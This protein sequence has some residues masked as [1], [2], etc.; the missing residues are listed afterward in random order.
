MPAHPE[1]PHA[2]AV[3]ITGLTPSIDGGRHPVK[4]ITD[5]PLVVEADVFKDGHDEIAAAVL[6]KPEGEG[7]WREVPMV[8][9]EN[10]RWTA[11]LR[12]A[13]PGRYEFRVAAWPDPLATWRHELRKKVEA[14]VVPLDLELQEG[15]LLVKGAAL[16][17]RLQGETEIARDLVQLGE[18][19]PGLP[20]REAL[21]LVESPEVAAVLAHW[22]DRALLTLH[23]VTHAVIVE[24]EKARF[25]AWYE[26]FPRNAI[27]DGVTHATFRDCRPALEHA[28]RMGFDVVY[29]PPIHPVGV[30]NRKGKNN[31][32]VCE[33]G[34]IGSP[35]AIG[36]PAG[37]HRAI[38]P[39]LGTMDDFQFF[40]GEARS[41]GLEVALDFALNCS[42]DHPYVR[43]H[44]GWFHV[45]PDGSMKFAENPPKKYEDIYPMNYHCADWRAQWDE[46]RDVILFWCEHGVRIFRVDNPHTKPVAF[47]E[48]VLAEVRR[49]YPDSIFLSEAFTRPKMMAEL[50]KVGFSQSYSYFT[51]RT[52]KQG[53]TDYLTELAQPPL[54]DFMRANF[55]PNTPDILAYELWHAPPAKFMVRAT[56]AATLMPS[57]G[58]Y[59][60]FEFCEND[61]FPPKEEYNNSEK[62][63]LVRRDWNAPGITGPIAA[64]N[65]IRRDNEACRHS[66]NIRFAH[67]P[68]SEV[69]AY[70]RVNPD[71]T[72]RLLVVVNLDVAR[73][74]ES[75]V[76][77]PLDFLGMGHDMSYCVRDLLT[78]EV[79]T[80]HGEQNFVSLDPQVRVAHVFRIEP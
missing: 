9:V 8:P 32:T 2:P 66:A 41:L 65:R 58:M 70:A 26:F 57:W 13:T 3:V 7:T 12:F 15:A 80:W 68:N 5:E 59:S 14:A 44:P 52:D 30:T 75:S 67:T 19:L 36:G 33:P 39:A 16:R 29:L 23:P 42:P 10:D 71:R 64:L 53:L 54:K 49:R 18:L 20:P 50:A 77:V 76:H 45:R 55:W 11:T 6:W 48:Y 56:L 46:I 62:Y 79:W 37:G 22:P 40:L 25:S 21:E 60:G 43:E 34:D 17:A 74:Q 61:P 38:E 1:V 69:I 78:G 31:A 72:N 24:R 51:W 35:W 27:A 28:V 47:W 4:R 73:C 63:Q